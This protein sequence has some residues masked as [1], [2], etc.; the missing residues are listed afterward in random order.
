MGLWEQS[1]EMRHH[2]VEMVFREYL[3]CMSV[4]WPL[5][6]KAE[7]EELS[8]VW[9]PGKVMYLPLYSV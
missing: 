2:P 7:V 1:R 3:V 5:S 8:L 6:H 4:V 9:A